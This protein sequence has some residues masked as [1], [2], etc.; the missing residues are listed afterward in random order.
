MTPTVRRLMTPRAA[1]PPPRN[2]IVPRRNPAKPA[3][4]ATTEPVLP[5]VV[6]T[7]APRGLHQDYLFHDGIPGIAMTYFSN[8]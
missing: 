2:E 3:R 1:R 6:N 4:P 5:F 8:V 7:L